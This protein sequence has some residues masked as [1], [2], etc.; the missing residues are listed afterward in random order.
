[1]VRVKYY[2]TLTTPGCS[3]ANNPVCTVPNVLSVRPVPVFPAAR[4]FQH[5]PVR[6]RSSSLPPLSGCPSS[7][8]ATEDN[9]S[10]VLPLESDRPLPPPA[11]RPR[12]PDSWTAGDR[13]LTPD[14]WPASSP[15]RYLSPGRHCTAATGPDSPERRSPE[16]SAHA[17]CAAALA[18][19]RVAA[20]AS[21]AGS[22][23]FLTSDGRSR[24]V[25][26]ERRSRGRA[27]RTLT[28]Q[29]GMISSA[30]ASETRGHYLGTPGACVRYVTR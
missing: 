12:S 27:R 24:E 2:F 20:G 26:P 18:A 11:G 19:A 5:P 8:A 28:P 25:T 23:R 7:A 6:R 13:G 14:P 4:P 30:A 17:A 29:T 9:P 1:M 22:V 10:C 15:E 21:A 16:R 3:H